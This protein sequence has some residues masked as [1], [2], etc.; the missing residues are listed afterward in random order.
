MA[1]KYSDDPSASLNLGS[2]GWVRWGETVPKFQSA[3]FMLEPGSVSSPVLTSFGYHVIVAEDRRLSDYQ[4][5][6]DEEFE[7]AIINLSKR[8]VRDKLRPAAIAYD[9]LQIIKSG[10]HFN[11]DAILKISQTYNNLLK[12]KY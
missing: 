6:S 1:K 7:S 12:K 9:S 11:S 5:L 8:T 4:Y 3:A 2:L 10:L